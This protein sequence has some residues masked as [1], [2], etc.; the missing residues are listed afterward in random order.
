MVADAWGQG[1]SAALQVLQEQLS[2]GE[3][4]LQIVHRVP[5]EVVLVQRFFDLSDVLVFEVSSSPVGLWFPRL[6]INPPLITQ[7]LRS[8]HFSL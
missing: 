2:L 8:I 3:L 5:A 1:P 6:L 7:R 4:R